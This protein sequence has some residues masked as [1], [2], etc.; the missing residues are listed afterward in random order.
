LV[1]AG[2]LV[3]SFEGELTS[4]RVLV[5]VMMAR[6]KHNNDDDRKELQLFVWPSHHIDMAHSLDK[7]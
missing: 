1:A 6:R 7:F 5:L 4:R 2:V 3:D